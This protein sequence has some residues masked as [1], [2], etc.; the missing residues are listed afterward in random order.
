MQQLNLENKLYV[1]I[2][3]DLSPEQK[4][5]QAGHAIAELLLDVPKERHKWRNGTLVYLE[6]EN[7]EEIQNYWEFF[8]NNTLGTKKGMFFEPYKDM[9]YT[10]L[11]V[12]GPSVENV[13]KD[14]TL[15]KM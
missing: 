9:G 12:I 7:E 11:A 5:V 13:L 3:K 2:R 8:N 4:A 15:M 10:A 14:L 6:V 1:L